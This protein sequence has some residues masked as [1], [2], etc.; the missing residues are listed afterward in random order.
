MKLKDIVNFLE[1]VLH[2]YEGIWT[3]DYQNMKTTNGKL[4]DYCLKA[5]LIETYTE[6]VQGYAEEYADL[7]SLGSQL[8]AM[9]TKA[10]QAEESK[11]EANATF[12]VV[13]S[14]EQAID[15]MKRDRKNSDKCLRETQE[16]L[17]RVRHNPLLK[18]GMF[19][20]PESFRALQDYTL[21]FS[22]SER[23]AAITSAEMAI[24]L[25]HKTIQNHLEAN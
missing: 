21:R 9:H 3:A 12:G 24:N 5:G 4:F 6:D 17:A 18:N 14:L 16:E 22:D 7:S 8:L 19:A 23:S 1:M 11:R 20:T 15:M 13:K 25:C 2:S 10:E